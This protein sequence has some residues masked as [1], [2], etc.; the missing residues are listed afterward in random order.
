M[1]IGNGR[2]YVITGAYAGFGLALAERLASAH[3]KL[4]ISGR[5]EA[6]LNATLEK[7]KKLTDVI[8]V[9]AD[10]TSTRDCKRLIDACVAAYGRIDVMVNNAGVLQH[11]LK[12][13]LVNNMVDPNLKGLEYCS[14]YA[15]SQMRKQKDG[16]VMLNV[17]S[18]SGAFLKPNEEEAIYA[19]T[20]FGAMAYTASLYLA[21]KDEKIKFLCFCP[22]GMKTELFRAAPN[23]EI[24]D[25]MDPNAAAGVLLKQLEAERFGL[26]VLLRRGKLQYSKDFSLSWQW[27]SE[28]E[29]D[30]KNYV[31]K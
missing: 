20:K 17:V 9:K 19:S 31:N 30:L 29:V 10:V 4:V 13:K 3:A 18:T 22:G 26:S 24:G 6:K 25:F 2:V 8:A 16:G 12:P 27:T 23:R 7:L 1:E 11:G 15:M 14:F 28:E 5:D 21:K